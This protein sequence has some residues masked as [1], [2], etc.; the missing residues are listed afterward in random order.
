MTTGLSTLPLVAEI[1]L[2]AFAENIRTIR[3]RLAPGCQL[4]AVLKA[5]AYGHGAGPLAAVASK[6]GVAWLGVARCQE[7]V[8]LR[9]YGIDAPI[10]IL[11]PLWPGEV[12]TL[13]AYRLT[14]TIGACED[15]ATLQRA[16]CQRGLVYPIHVKIDTGMGRFGVTPDCVPALLEQLG[17]CSH[18]HLDGLMTHLACADTSDVESVQ[19]QLA[20][21][22]IVLQQ[23]ATQGLTPRYIHAANSAGLYRYPESH[24]TL[25]RSGI[26]LYGAHPFPTPEAAALRPV[27]TWKTY[28]A[29]V[30]VVPAG[31]GISYGY[32]FVTSR[33]SVIGTLPV[34]YAD[35]LSRNL[36]NV[37]QVLI[38]GHRV[39]VVGQVC[40]DMCMVDLTDL[41]CAHVGDEV[42]LL[43][44][45]GD[46]RIT[47]EEIAARCGCIP[48]EV[49]C[50]I[51]QRVPRRYVGTE[52]HVCH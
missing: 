31:C 52:N 1:D 21:F 40:M 6:H 51:S 29:R 43:G 47:A 38:H 48:Y 49:F 45:Q 22:R 26:A 3:T 8:A 2:G 11:G 36:S 23:F 41:A 30:Q 18:L 35:G 19:C 34:G 27:L 33:P 39:P 5:D 13:I 37:G 28:L 50:A 24:W 12:E 7:G 25:V 44:A 32:T 16:A 42:V 9:Q 46:D 17:T 4:M 15:A 10:L 20:R 14:P